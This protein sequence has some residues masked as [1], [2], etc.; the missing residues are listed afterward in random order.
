MAP[1]GSRGRPRDPRGKGFGKVF[2]GRMTPRRTGTTASLCGALGV[3][4][5]LLAGC[6]A[7]PDPSD[8]EAVAEFEQINDPAEPTNRVIFEFNRFFSDYSPQ[9][10]DPSREKYKDIHGG[11]WKGG[12]RDIAGQKATI[13]IP[14]AEF[15]GAPGQTIRMLITAGTFKGSKFSAVRL[16]LK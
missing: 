1:R 13:T 5:A 14:Y 10:W 2:V 3:V 9:L 16:E 15:K 12:R 4:L 8:R 7:A 6:A 11:F